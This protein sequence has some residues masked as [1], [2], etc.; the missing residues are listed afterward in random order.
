MG[1]FSGLTKIVTTP[2]EILGDTF[3]DGDNPIESAQRR[4][5]EIDENFKR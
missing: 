1:L 5:R 2:F 3:L 4:A